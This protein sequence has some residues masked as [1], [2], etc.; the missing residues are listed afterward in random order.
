[1]KRRG[2][3]IALTTVAVGLVVLVA[4]GIA[5]KNWIR[6]GWWLH[7]LAMGNHDEQ[8][9]AAKELGEMQ[10]LRAVPT[11]ID[12]LTQAA[13]VY[14]E[15]QELVIW[16][17]DFFLGEALGKIGRPGLPLLLEACNN[18]NPAVRNAGFVGLVNFPECSEDFDEV[19]KFL[20]SLQR[21]CTA[22]KDLREGAGAALKKIRATLASKAPLEDS[23]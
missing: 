2:K 12:C 9:L 16:E 22:R 18:A 20:D 10:S 23:R 21:D 14:N 8:K 19:P 5:A 11:L 3:A 13:V 4:A 15:E 1:M 7:K 6:E 17:K